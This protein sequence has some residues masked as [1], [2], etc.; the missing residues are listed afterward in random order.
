MEI[1]ESARARRLRL[2]IRPGQIRLTVPRS[3]P[4]ERIQDFLISQAT[5]LETHT[6]PL[7]R[8]AGPNEGPLSAIIP[9]PTA[10]ARILFRGMRI[11]FESQLTPEA[12]CSVYHE[13]GLKIWMGLPARWDVETRQVRGQRALHRWFDRILRAEALMW[14]RG[15]GEPRGLIPEKILFGAPRTRWGS[16]SRDGVIRLNRRLIGAPLNVYRYVVLHELAHLRF[17]HHQRPFWDLV[18][19]LDPEWK[20]HA[21]WLRHFGVA[22][23]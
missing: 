5:W 10:S 14:V 8:L 4:P 13:P 7:R 20:T 19:E 2:E 11:A 1:R 9:E 17:P 16:C 15:Y 18:G 21:N 22:L 12:Q 6:E 3:C 23:G